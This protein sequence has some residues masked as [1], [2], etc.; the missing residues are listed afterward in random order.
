MIVR[1]AHENGHGVVAGGAARW[2]HHG[3]QSDG[4]RRL[5]KEIPPGVSSRRPPPGSRD[6]SGDCT[7]APPAAESALIGVKAETCRVW[8]LDSQLLARRVE[9]HREYLMPAKITTTQLISRIE[10]DPDI[11]A[12]DLLPPD[13]FARHA[14]E[15]KPYP[16]IR[17][18]HSAADAGKAECDQWGLTAEEWVE[19]MDAARFA[20]AHDMKLD[21]IKKGITPAM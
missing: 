9:T 1:V 21:L 20:L 17:A 8:H 18:A 5:A 11:Y 2:V 19:E 12:L 14:Y 13:S 4:R 10:V 16:A 15:T 7:V 6:G 3:R